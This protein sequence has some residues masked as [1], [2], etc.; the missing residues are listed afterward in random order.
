MNQKNK[1]LGC[2][3]TLILVAFFLF[4]VFATSLIIGTILDPSG[5]T[6]DNMMVDGI[7]MSTFALIVLI[8]IYLAMGG[9]LIEIVR[10]IK[11]KDKSDDY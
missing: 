4:A 3:S 5:L 9:K 8:I 10:R 11:G 7:Q 1:N 6:D 2:L